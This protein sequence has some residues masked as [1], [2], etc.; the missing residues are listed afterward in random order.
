MMDNISS[1]LGYV[2]RNKRLIELALTHKSFS[3]EN[4]ERLE[5]L[6][7]AILNLYV[8]EKLYASYEDL[9][10]G[11]LTRF[12]ASIVSRDNL[13]LVALNLEIGEGIKLGKGEKLEGNSIL[14]NTL[15]ALIGAVFLDSNF[16]ETKQVLDN[17]F[18][19][20]FKE[21]NRI[22]ELKD[23]KSCLQELIQKKY[24]SLPR[25]SSKENTTSSYKIRFEATCY[26]DEAKLRSNGTA[27]TRKGA[28]LEAAAIMLKM[29]EDN[30]S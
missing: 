2:F 25:Y 7:D 14:G 19:H 6:G 4:N 29:L 12:K 23:P 10:E 27:K 15:E 18:S 20:N 13:N 5:F 9:N 21:L 24:K 30:D 16:N 26:V 11:K 17:L 8:S 3:L 1:N 28:E 22:D